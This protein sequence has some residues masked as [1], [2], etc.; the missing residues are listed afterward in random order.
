MWGRYQRLHAYQRPITITQHSHN[1]ITPML[2]II[3]RDSYQHC[4][5][6]PSGV[7][8]CD[9]HPRPP[10]IPPPFLHPHPSLHYLWCSFPLEE[11]VT[12]AVGASPWWG[13][14]ATLIYR[15]GI[16]DFNQVLH[17]ELSGAG[18]SVGVWEEHSLWNR[19]LHH[20]CISQ[21]RYQHSYLHGWYNPR[22]ADN[23]P[24]WPGYRV[25]HV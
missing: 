14:V 17:L 13:A 16:P 6:N 8:N 11:G 9:P 18:W 2:M 22:P 21:S 3:T 23:T 5:G 24:G 4:H 7:S 19:D 25:S 20:T 12:V 1:P 10:N 15:G